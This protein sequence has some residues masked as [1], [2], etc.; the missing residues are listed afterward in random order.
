MAVRIGEHAERHTGHTLGRLDCSAAELLDSCERRLDVLDAD[1]EQDG[2]GAT[3]Q[4]PDGGRKCSF[5]SG[6]REGVAGKGAVGVRPAKELS[7]E[8]A[9]CVPAEAPCAGRRLATF[10]A[11]AV[12]SREMKNGVG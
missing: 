6:V 4:R 5:D 10:P 3:L 9:C 8:R 2:V 7:K 1:K 11:A 12:G